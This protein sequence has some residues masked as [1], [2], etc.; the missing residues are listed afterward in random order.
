MWGTSAK[1]LEG[2]ESLLQPAAKSGRT[3]KQPF[4]A[5]SP[6]PR[7]GR[8]FTSTYAGFSLRL[9]TPTQRAAS[10]LRPAHS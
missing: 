2:L 3:H 5:T 4:R 6:L 10:W 9:P 8:S 1:E 7:S